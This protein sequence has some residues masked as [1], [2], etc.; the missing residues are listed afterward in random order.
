M[1]RVKETVASVGG[2]C[3]GELVIGESKCNKT[4]PCVMGEMVKIASGNGLGLHNAG[5]NHD[6]NSEM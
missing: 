2:A 1:C 5:N 6:V 4:E 3:A